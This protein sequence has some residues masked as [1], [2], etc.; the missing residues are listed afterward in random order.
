MTHQEI[1]RLQK[2]AKRLQGSN[3]EVVS[4]TLSGSMESRNYRL[5]DTKIIG[6][7]KIHGVGEEPTEDDMFYTAFA[8]L[9]SD[10]E[11]LDLFPLKL[12]LE[13]IRSNKVLFRSY[14]DQVRATTT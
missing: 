7:G 11:R 13:T 4:R 8:V 14:F 5:V 2:E 12:V 10:R 1:N 3:V 9:E 6:F